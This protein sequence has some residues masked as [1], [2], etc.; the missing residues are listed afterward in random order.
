MLIRSVTVNGIGPFAGRNVIR[1][2]PRRT[3]VHGQNGTGKSVLFRA[4]RARLQ[5]V[6]DVG[7]WTCWAAGAVGSGGTWDD[8]GRV[9]VEVDGDRETHGDDCHFLNDDS[10][11]L[12]LYDTSGWRSMD[13]GELDALNQHLSRHFARML[14]GDRRRQDVVPTAMVN[15]EAFVMRD[16]EGGWIRMA[17]HPAFTAGGRFVATF[18]LALALRDVRSPRSPLVIDSGFLGGLERP[19]LDRVTRELARLDGQVVLFTSARDVARQL[20][21]DHELVRS[22]RARGVRTVRRNVRR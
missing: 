19:C 22:P 12:L 18:A 3:V 20:G 1:F 5:V 6:G 16:I 2:N 8:A 13:D 15:R 9:H 7:A 10:L 14:P 11:G 17:D 4:M 21:I